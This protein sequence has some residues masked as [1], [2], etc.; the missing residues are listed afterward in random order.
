MATGL[1]VASNY[2]AQP[3]L[4]PMALD[5]D[6]GLAWPVAKGMGSHAF[7]CGIDRK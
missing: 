1:A 2:D 5:L 4:P 3:L 7:C 6:L